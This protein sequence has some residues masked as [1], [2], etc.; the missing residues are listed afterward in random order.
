M[1][2]YCVVLVVSF[3]FVGALFPCQSFAHHKAKVLGA[4]TAS[5]ELVFPA[6]TSGPGFILPDSPF[7]FLDNFVQNIR[8]ATAFTPERK[9][10]V[11]SQIAGERLAEL[12]LMMENN[13]ENGITT[14]LDQL[15]QEMKSAANELSQADAQGEDIKELAKK[16]NNE[17]KNQRDILG[18][19]E[20]QA[21]GSLL[22]RIKAARNE[23]KEAKVT[24]EDSLPQEDF[25]REIEESVE[26]E[27]HEAVKDASNSARGLE[28][29]ILVLEELASQ[30]ATKNQG[31]RVEALQQAIANKN[32][33]IRRQA[34]RELEAEAKKIQELTQT[35]KTQINEARKAVRQAQEAAKIFTDVAK[36][37]KEIKNTKATDLETE[38][39]ST[40]SSDSSENS[41]E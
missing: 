30:A 40:P 36:E 34:E 27:I 20:E 26:D 22:L 28:H 6:V 4:S 9:A 29:S 41:S 14:A 16:V 21:G 33:A 37:A 15:S 18:T 19:L 13:N 1:K 32:E 38:K 23:L 39:S 8:L 10:E 2:R 24:V 12:R 7:Y 31:R 17:I 25:E 3:F 11:R 35:R 5:S